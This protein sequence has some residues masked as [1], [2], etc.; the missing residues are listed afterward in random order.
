M[1]SRNRKSLS[2]NEKRCNL[3][4]VDE[5]QHLKRV[6]LAKELGLPV[7]TLNTLIYKRKIIEESHHQS[8]SSASK[9]LRVQRGKLA[10]VEKVL[11]RWFNQCRNVKI[12][13]SGLLLMEA[14][15][16]EFRRI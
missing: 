7:S 2:L 3:K 4:K 15:H 6:D 8:G 9:K 1:T 16:K 13:I 11:L 14:L 5:N 12:L 10:D